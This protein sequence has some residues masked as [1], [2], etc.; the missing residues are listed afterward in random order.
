M[1]YAV[2]NG[3]DGW[4]V[5]MLMHT[6]PIQSLH[7]YVHVYIHIY[8]YII[9]IYIYI[10]LHIYPNSVYKRLR[11]FAKG[12]RVN[13]PEPRHGDS[14]FGGKCG[15]ANQPEDVAKSP[16]KSCLFFVRYPVPGIGLTGDR[17]FGTVKHRGSCGVQCTLGNP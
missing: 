7:T 6:Y 14:L 9:C 5:M 2:Y 12:N 16:G 17:D 3:M 8:I 1:V 13:I 15:N 11:C 4:M 10:Y